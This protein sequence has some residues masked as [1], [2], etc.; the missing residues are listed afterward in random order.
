M[1]TPKTSTF[2]VVCATPSCY[3]D[4]AVLAALLDLTGVSL[5]ALRQ[6]DD[7]QFEQAADDV[8][9]HLN[10]QDSSVAGRNS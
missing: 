3:Q 4:E 2:D 8:L 5:K 6:C 9:R 10:R 1:T 7:D